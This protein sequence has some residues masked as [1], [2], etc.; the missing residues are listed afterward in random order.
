MEARN[1][2]GRGAHQADQTTPDMSETDIARIYSKLDEVT[3]EL[4]ELRDAVIAA[5]ARDE[6]RDETRSLNVCPAPGACLDLKPRVEKLEN[7]VDAHRALIER[8]RG[9]MMAAGAIGGAIGAMPALVAFVVQML[10]T[11]S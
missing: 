9:M 11:T 6:A 7:T 4:R 10:K 2:H 5:K 8:G 3:G 1:T